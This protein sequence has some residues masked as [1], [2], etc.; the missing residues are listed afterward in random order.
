MQAY[1]L[2]PLA[3]QLVTETVYLPQ[4][5]EHTKAKYTIHNNGR[6]AD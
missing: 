5:K 2:A 3:M 1:C 6:L 4:N